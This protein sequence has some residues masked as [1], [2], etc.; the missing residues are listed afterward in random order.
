M[1]TN[2]SYEENEKELLSR[3]QS[4]ANNDTSVDLVCLITSE[5]SSEQKHSILKAARARA[6]TTVAK[7]Q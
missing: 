4:V 6:K 3:A 2:Q 7:I 1:K 5:M